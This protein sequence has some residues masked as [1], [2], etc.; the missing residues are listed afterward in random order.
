MKRL[1]AAAPFLTAALLALASM[2]VLLSCTPAS[3]SDTRL[4]LVA[5]GDTIMAT[6]FLK[7]GGSPDSSVAL[8]SVRN[9][10]TVRLKIAG[11]PNGVSTSLGTAA[12][13]PSP[14]LAEGDTATV[15][16]CVTLYKRN[17]APVALSCAKA[18]FT[19]PVVPPTGTV[20]SLKLAR[21]IVSPK[22]VTMFAGAG[23]QFCA[24][25]TPDGGATIVPVAN[26][27][28]ACGPTPASSFEYRRDVRLR[29]KETR[30]TLAPW[31]RGEILD[32][33]WEVYRAAQAG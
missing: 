28:P 13:V 2:V 7:V 33:P 6:P 25:Y 3:A 17:T 15:S 10:A 12:L 21:I 8:V 27:S 31:F 20:D 11:P 18:L 23:Q 26:Q 22:T 9:A 19:R 30:L 32:D 5:V 16:A 24:Y 29:W 14:A 4:R 1:L